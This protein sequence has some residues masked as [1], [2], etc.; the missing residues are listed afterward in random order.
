MDFD[1]D[2]FELLYNSFINKFTK[3]EINEFVNN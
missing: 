2:K 1:N 3:E